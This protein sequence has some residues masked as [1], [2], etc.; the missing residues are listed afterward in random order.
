M[1]IMYSSP[2]T[3]SP[4]KLA[5]TNL[6]GSQI[7]K[8]LKLVEA[9]IKMLTLNL[10]NERYSTTLPL[11]RNCSGR[12]LSCTMHVRINYLVRSKNHDGRLFGRHV[13]L[14]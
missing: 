11:S 3:I 4:N 8:A 10:L 6:S 1:V 13:G 14:T 2:T 12:L 5:P 9:Q 7:I